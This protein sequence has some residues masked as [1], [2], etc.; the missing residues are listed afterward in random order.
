MNQY[1]DRVNPIGKRWQV[2]VALLAVWLT[3]EQCKPS[4][5]IEQVLSAVESSKRADL[6]YVLSYYTKPQDSLKHQAAVFL[7]ENFPREQYYTIDRQLLIENIELAFE[8]WKR[9]W[10]Q[11]V[12]FEEFKDLILPFELQRDEKGVFWR[13]RFLQ[14]Y[15]YLADSVARYPGVN[16]TLAACI[17]MNHAFRKKYLAE[18]D[19][20]KTTT[21]SLNDWERIRNGDCGD[22]ASLT[23]HAMHAVG[24]P[25]TI[26]FTPQWGNRSYRH[27]WNVV[28]F[29]GRFWPFAGTEGYPGRYKVDLDVKYNFFKK[30]TTIF[31][32]YYRINPNS[33]A[34]IAEYDSKMPSAFSDPTIVDVG[35]E[36]LPVKDVGLQ[37]PES[38]DDEYL[39]LC[40]VHHLKWLPVAWSKNENGKVLF[41]NVNPNVLYA[42]GRIAPGLDSIILV[43]HPFV[44]KRDGSRRVFEPHPSQREQVT[45]LRKH[46]YD[47]TNLIKLGDLYQLN[48]WNKDSGWVPLQQQIARDRKVV[49]NNIPKN[50]LLLLRNLDRGRQERA[51]YYLNGTQVF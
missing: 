37:V 1:N 27:F 47:D 10:A 30:R 26:E 34:V 41:K 24:V 11:H 33:L 16:P 14:E 19:R 28:W 48:Y 38:I 5:R 9:P 32:K 40:A 7:V 8:V 36:Y 15:H 45:C 25:T 21:L 42:L 13:K 39:F 3:F 35:K 29:N 51:F 18:F 6:E 44:L 43:N 12:S 22:M 31:R 23:Y 50:A 49:F 2:A 46:A 4:T 20:D 17:V